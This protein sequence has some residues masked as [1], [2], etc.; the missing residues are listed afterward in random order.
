MPHV[1]NVMAVEVTPYL[2]ARA[3]RGWV[4][5]DVKVAWVEVEIVT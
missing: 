3:A 4:M 2:K 1:Q 5:V